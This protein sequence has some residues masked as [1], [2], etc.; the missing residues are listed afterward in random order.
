[1]SSTHKFLIP[2]K[3]GGG[4]MT[5]NLGSIKSR[6][7]TEPATKTNSDRVG[8]YGMFKKFNI[9]MY[10]NTTDDTSPFFHVAHLKSLVELFNSRFIYDKYD[11]HKQESEE[12]GKDLDAEIVIFFDI[13]KKSL[14]RIQSSNNRVKVT[15]ESF[16]VS[17]SS[18]LDRLRNTSSSVPELF[19]SRFIDIL[20]ELLTESVTNRNIM[21]VSVSSNLVIED[22]GI[23]ILNRAIRKS[24][25]TD[26]IS[27][28]MPMDLA[29]IPSFLNSCKALGARI[30][31]GSFTEDPST[32]RTTFFD[33][34]TYFYSRI[35]KNKYSDFY[36]RDISERFVILFKEYGPVTKHFLSF[37]FESVAGQKTDPKFDLDRKVSNLDSLKISGVP[38][39]SLIDSLTGGEIYIVNGKEVT[40]DGRKYGVGSVKKMVDL[41]MLESNR[42]ASFENIQK[43]AYD[44][45]YG[46]R[47]GKF[48][49]YW[50]QK[51]GIDRAM[52]G[53]S[54]FLTGP[55]S[56]GKTYAA[57]LIIAKIVS[58]LIKESDSD[59]FVFCAPTD[60]LALQTF[61]NMIESFP[62]IVD[63]ISLICNG[64]VKGSPSARV[65]IGT[66]KELRDFFISR[67]TSVI[68]ELSISERDKLCG[69]VS[70]STMSTIYSLIVDEVHIMD[71]TYDSS[72]DGKRASKS[73]EELL[74]ALV[75]IPGGKINQFIGL[76]AT[77]SD[78]SIQQLNRI[79]ED[80]TGI[81][82]GVETIKYNLSNFAAE[83]EPDDLTIGSHDPLPQIR[84]RV[85]LDHTGEIMN[86]ISSDPIPKINV[87]SSFIENLVF[88]CIKEKVTPTAF[89]F[90]SEVKAI[91]A[92]RSLLSY[93]KSMISLQGV[94]LNLSSNYDVDFKRSGGSGEII[95]SYIDLIIRGIY[96]LAETPNNNSHTV[97][98]YL[99]DP[100]VKFF[101]DNSQRQKK[102]T[103]IAQLSYSPDFYALLFEF[104]TYTEK[105]VLFKSRVH[106]FYNFG[107]SQ[108]DEDILDLYKNGTKT[109]FAIMLE[110]QGININADNQLISLILEGLSYG[111]GLTTSSVPVGIQV[112]IAKFLKRAKN[113]LN[114][115]MPGVRFTF[116]DYGMSMGVD[117]PYSGVA[118]IRDDF[119][120]LTLSEF[121]QMNG[122]AGRNKGKGVFY[123]AIT[124]LVNISMTKLISADESLRFDLSNISADFYSR[125]NIYQVL[126]GIISLFNSKNKN[127]EIIMR[128]TQEVVSFVDSSLFPGVDMIPDLAGKLSLMKKQVRELFEICKV[129][130]PDVANGYLDQL[131]LFFQKAGYDNIINTA[132]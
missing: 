124:F 127:K 119:T 90:E 100:L 3:T 106:P 111:I 126:S 43:A 11:E 12:A 115:N 117:Y 38:F 86:E 50:W 13:Y 25:P 18:T 95:K 20:S 79:V 63:K 15:L 102:L 42:T 72:D 60:P 88:K 64:V 87:T 32:L 113:T 73:I 55:T 2:N 23:E 47:E 19:S 129:I 17:F 30:E 76:S 120:E 41:F 80:K 130:A 84:Y 114:E 46:T 91:G 8:S 40:V 29:G 52:A 104:K 69:Y 6:T 61:S 62:K 28:L 71:P 65:Y 7:T 93:I 33:A 121:L 122:R 83:L 35:F 99:F 89:F 51:K 101:D 26:I 128:N 74:T 108:I 4:G 103:N 39:R 36:Q 68:S 21:S 66:P 48:T 97:P 82:S 31:T 132:A 67:N 53:L 92:M 85:K 9:F 123:R 70:S 107:D 58:S 10:K 109:D 1:M 118:I 59:I 112:E 24:S 131:F 94:W 34:L 49:P 16:N 81:R 14:N 22:S 54:F 57:M 56:G 78:D 77:L 125:D 44:K 75:E 96:D 5:M 98:R 105:G 110:A 37:I 116:S 45:I 27:S